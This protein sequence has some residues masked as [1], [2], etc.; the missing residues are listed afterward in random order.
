MFSFLKAVE[1]SNLTIVFKKITTWY[2][3]V[4]CFYAVCM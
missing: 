4:L 1:I 2:V 3:S